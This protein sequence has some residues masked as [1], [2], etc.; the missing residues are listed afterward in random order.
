[1]NCGRHLAIISELS[2]SRFLVSSMSTPRTQ[3]SILLQTDI[4]ECQLLG[5]GKVRDIYQAG[6][7]LLIVATDRISAFDVVLPT[8]IPR[9]GEVL[10]Q[11]SIFWFDFLKDTVP[12]HFLT[13][14]VEKYPDPLPKYRDQL[15]RRSMLVRKADMFPI[16][17]VA[18]AY[19]S[20]SSWKEYQASGTVCGIKLPAGIR[21]SGKLPETIFTPAT[22]AHDGHDENISFDRA[23]EIVGRDLTEKLRDLT[24][25]IFDKC[26]QYALACGLVLADTKFEF[27]RCGEIILADEVLTP[28]S[29]RYWPLELY[30]PGRPQPSY[31]KQF[32]RDY[33]ES[34][35]FNK[36][37]PGPELPPDI[38][39]QTSEKYLEAYY[40]L[41]G[42]DLDEDD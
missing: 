40:T 2:G 20:G 9:K 7:N 41:T 6:D 36:Q 18:R 8:G 37:P 21:E 19:L 35:H 5:R 23:A 30:H 28:D 15:H 12:T 13:A 38:V 27:G 1:L 10:T 42:K 25:E 14:D 33:L 29:S 26:S 24:I 31:D 16:E 34:I 11:L 4:P 22:K 3:T 39:R 17:C 32:V